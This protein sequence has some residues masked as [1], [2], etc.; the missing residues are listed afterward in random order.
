MIAGSLN[1]EFS[2][3]ANYPF[4]IKCPGHSNECNI[5]CNSSLHSCAQMTVRA[6]NDTELSIVASGSNALL[7]SRIFCPLLSGTCSIIASGMGI[8][9]DFIVYSVNGLA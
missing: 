3:R 2:G 6:Q 4:T 9:S 8:F 5:F 7:S 1:V